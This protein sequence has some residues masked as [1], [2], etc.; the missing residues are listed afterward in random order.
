MEVP[1]DRF[2]SSKYTYIESV[3]RKCLGTKRNNSFSG[4]SGISTR[5]WLTDASTMSSCYFY[6]WVHMYMY[7]H[8]VYYTVYMYST[9][10]GVRH[11][12][13]LITSA[14]VHWY[15][16]THRQTHTLFSM[17]TLSESRSTAHDTHNGPNHYSYYDT[18]PARE[19]MYT[20]VH[21]CIMLS[22][23]VW[24]HEKSQVHVRIFTTNPNPSGML[25]KVF[26][27]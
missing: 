24:I 12:L 15:T 9:I 17:C 10:H 8:N 27:S 16:H 3:G 14:S 23:S 11:C 7:M 18:P 13:L 20:T 22:W 1:S 26:S 25:F 5:E 4:E 2:G 6:I 21:T 19:Y